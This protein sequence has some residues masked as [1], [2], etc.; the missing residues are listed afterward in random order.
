MATLKTTPHTVATIDVGTNT[1][2]LLISR[3]EAGRLISLYDETRFV[4]LGQGVDGAG[5]VNDAAMD[6]LSQTLAYYKEIAATWQVADIVIGATSASRDAANKAA[7]IAHVRD[8]TGLNYQIISGKTE[9]E[10][11]FAGVGAGQAAQM[12]AAGTSANIASHQSILTVDIGG[13][14]TEF[15]LGH[16]ESENY[17]LEHAQSLNVGSVRLTERF[18]KTLPPQPA[19][20]QEAKHWLLEELE[21]LNPVLKHSDS[22]LI[23]ASGTTTVLAMLH[24]GLSKADLQGRSVLGDLSAAQVASWY[25]QLVQMPVEEVLAL[26][27]AFMKGREDVFGAGVFILH[28]LMQYL[29]KPKV[30][31]NTWGLRHG[32]ALRYWQHNS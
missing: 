32:L 25:K 2:L 28:T 9:A 30:Y 11:S 1:A 26:G 3:Y 21:T 13:G 20:L 17:T 19:M 6:R 4:R 10:L 27:P 31:V 24:A 5:V 8:T 7:L 15:S 29:E 14:S 23:G 16:R 12:H 22:A 18:F